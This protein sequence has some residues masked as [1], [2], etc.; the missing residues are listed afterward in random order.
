MKQR[1]ST[2]KSWMSNSGIYN[3]FTCLV[4][5]VTCIVD[6]KDLIPIVLFSCKYESNSKTN[7]NYLTKR[8]NFFYYKVGLK[9]TI[10]QIGLNDGFYW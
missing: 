8:I 4:Q 2:K 3:H 10:S 1:L 5:R 7:L 9:T 6:I